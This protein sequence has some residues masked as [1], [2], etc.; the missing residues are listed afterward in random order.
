ML[1]PQKKQLDLDHDHTNSVAS[2]QHQA[3]QRLS[4]VKFEQ[5]WC[6]RASNSTNGDGN[7][8]R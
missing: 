1:F 6:A 5:M 2:L 8:L 7:A 3:A 4:A